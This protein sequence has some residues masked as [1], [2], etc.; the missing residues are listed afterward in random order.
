MN[1]IGVS[2]ALVNKYN[3]QGDLRYVSDKVLPYV[4][5]FFKQESLEI[6]YLEEIIDELSNYIELGHVQGGV[7]NVCQLVIFMSQNDAMFQ[8]A[9]QNNLVGNL[10]R[11][12]L[13]LCISIDELKHPDGN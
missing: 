11:A 1:A 5:E 12:I 9:L 2:P 6:N 7:K 3:T 4:S 10:L 13:S 8:D